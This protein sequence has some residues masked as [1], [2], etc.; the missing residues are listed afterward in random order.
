[1]YHLKESRDLN[2]QE[3][4][5]TFFGLAKYLE[6]QKCFEIYDS[7]EILYFEFKNKE[8]LKNE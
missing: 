5:R 3:I 7:K 2:E 1:M 6:K 4:L 8:V